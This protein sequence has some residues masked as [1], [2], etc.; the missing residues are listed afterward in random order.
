[1][2]LPHGMTARESFDRFEPATQECRPA[3]GVPDG[4][5]RLEKT[6]CEAHNLLAALADRIDLALRP[7]LPD[8]I[9]ADG[10]RPASSRLAGAL[11][12]IN[13]RAGALCVRLRELVE[14]VD[15]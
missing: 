9:K 8:A 4:L 3:A 5:D 6:L 15:L 2:P 11:D 10:V 7:A 1:M 14:R 12:E 13:G